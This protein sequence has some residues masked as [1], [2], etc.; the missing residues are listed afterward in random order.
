[1]SDK[2]WPSWTDPLGATYAPGDLIA[3]AAVSGSSAD[4]RFGYVVR[5]NS[6]NSSGQPIT[7]SYYDNET[8]EHKTVPSA[9]VTL[10][11][12]EPS[13]GL[14]KKG[15]S[16]NTTKSGR[17][18]LKTIHNI[19]NVVAVSSTPDDIDGTVEKLIELHG[20]LEGGSE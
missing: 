19:G 4:M 6:V 13:T 14:P 8:K 7:R 2:E 12:V 10:V 3:Y 5:I 20:Q 1:M 11:E 15:Y 9:T 17:A 18:R 16:W